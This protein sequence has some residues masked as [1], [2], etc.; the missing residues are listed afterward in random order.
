MALWMHT[1]KKQEKNY[2]KEKSRYNDLFL[3]AALQ[4]PPRQY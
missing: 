2:R 4:P 3:I 1:T